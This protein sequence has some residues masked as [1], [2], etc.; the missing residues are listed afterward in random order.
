MNK[1]FRKNA[2]HYLRRNNQVKVLLGAVLMIG[3]TA[4]STTPPRKPDN[5]CSIFREKNHWYDAAVASNEKWG[6]P[7]HVMMAMMYQESSFRHD[8][9][10]PMQ[11][12]FGFIPIGRASSAYGYAQAKTLTWKD[13]IKETGH[14]GAD[15]DDFDDAIDFMGWFIYKTQRL[16]HVSKWNAYDQYL[17]YHEGWGGYRRGHYRS[18]K[19]LIRVANKVK[20]RSLRYASQY[21][22]CKKELESSG[23]WSGLF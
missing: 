7:I 19:W 21:K 14:S 17:S 13:Y 23:F 9:E 10:P 20:D 16:N 4:C 2:R 18:K 8:A 22:S 1:N 11:Y 15:R 3:L 6:A 12:F 5:L